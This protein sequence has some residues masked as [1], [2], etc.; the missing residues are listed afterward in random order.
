[1][2]RLGQVCPAGGRQFH[3]ISLTRPE[4]R[5]L[6]RLGQSCDSSGRRGGSRARQTYRPISHKPQYGTVKLR[7]LWNRRILI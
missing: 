1:M 6:V 4:G 7:A 5:V 2:R 3:R